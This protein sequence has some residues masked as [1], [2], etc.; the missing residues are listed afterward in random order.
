MSDTDFKRD[1]AEIA[2]ERFKQGRLTRR[3]FVTAMTAL[4]VLPAL[5]RGAMA[6]ASE[7]V[8][9]NWGGQGSVV[10]D[11]VLGKTYTELTGIKVSVDGGGPSPGKVRAMVESG[12]VVWD[13]CDSGAGSA[14]VMNE[15][16]VIQP[17]DYSIVD[18]TKVLKGTDLPFGVGNY[19]FS[20]VL[21]YNPQM[22]DGNVPKTWEDVWNVKDFPGMRTFR[23]SVRGQLECA[24]LAM[25][26]K[27]EEVYDFLDEDGIKAALEKFR[28]IRDD[29][30]VWG[31][32]ADSENLFLQGEV[33]M[34]NIYST[35]A[36]LLKDSMEEGTF[37]TT[38]E[39]GVVQPGIWVV[40]K[41]NPAGTE[42]V[43]KFIA[44]CQDPQLQ[45]EW[46]KA[47][48]NA[49]INPEAASMVPA[50]LAAYNPSSP[51]NL[52]VQVIYNDEWYAKNQVS[53]E[54]AYINALIN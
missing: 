50:E 19:V 42:A 33:A 23:K 21:C 52:A 9:A 11:E 30:I 22:L 44:H 3:G 12:A 28:S 26:I 13:L 1:L 24:A 37:A 18:R 38:F 4:G 2:A 16:G 48:G 14:M 6:Q 46:F 7:I 15:A 17:I 51:E 53:A 32:G 10:V 29:I 36:F 31:S 49:P 34:G 8:V 54:E 47:M 5:S 43:M 41:D 20:Y 35:R 25:G 45:V 39:G 40:P 27:R